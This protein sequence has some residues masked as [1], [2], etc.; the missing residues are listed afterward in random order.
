M[1]EGVGYRSFSNSVTAL[2][3]SPRSMSAMSRD[4]PWRTTM[5]M[6]IISSM[7]LGMVYAGTIQP[8]CCKAACRS[9]SVHLAFLSYSG[10]IIQMN[11]GLTT[12]LA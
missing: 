8:L 6:T 5:R 4:M 10:S 1:R 11:S 2:R 7:F 3:M 12:S 9:N